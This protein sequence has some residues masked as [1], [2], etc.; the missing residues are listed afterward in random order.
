MVALS[1]QQY[2]RLAA[3]WLTVTSFVVVLI[4]II[5]DSFPGAR[6]H[7]LEKTANASTNYR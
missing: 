7:F 5:C 6:L 3:Y 4:Y 1:Q 2:V